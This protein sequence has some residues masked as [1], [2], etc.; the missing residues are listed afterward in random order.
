MPIQKG[1]WQFIVHRLG[2]GSTGV[3]LDGNLAVSWEAPEV[4]GASEFVPSEV[5]W[6]LACK[7]PGWGGA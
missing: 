5:L 3:Q 7:E 4:L 1:D 6:F 2:L